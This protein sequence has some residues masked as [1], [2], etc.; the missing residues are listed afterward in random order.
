MQNGRRHPGWDMGYEGRVISTLDVGT[1]VIVIGQ[2]EEA[3]VMD[4]KTP[5]LTYSDYHVKK[6]GSTPPNA[7]SYQENAG[8][9]VGYRCTVCGYVYEGESLPP[10]FRCPLCHAPAEKFVKIEK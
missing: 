8:R 10:D 4:E 2:V 7:P 9:T 1:H 5:G 3:E 6:N